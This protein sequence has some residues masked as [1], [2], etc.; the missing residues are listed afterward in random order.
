MQRP[1]RGA[2]A[3]VPPG[4]AALRQL[5]QEDGV[6][7]AILE[8]SLDLPAGA[9]DERWNLI[10]RYIPLPPPRRDDSVVMNAQS[11]RRAI[12]RGYGVSDEHRV[13]CADLREPREQL[14]SPIPG[15]SEAEVAAQE[16]D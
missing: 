2:N 6:I 1:N 11:D 12:G 10:C 9:L 14:A 13:W 3:N 16:E 5:A 8:L 7:D 15:A 4:T